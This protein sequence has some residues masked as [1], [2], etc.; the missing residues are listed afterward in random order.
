M[1]HF[2]TEREHNIMARYQLYENQDGIGGADI[3][4]GQY[5][6][7]QDIQAACDREDRCKRFSLYNRGGGVK[8]PWCMKYTGALGSRRDDHTFFKKM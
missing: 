8:T 6:R 5:S 4:C 7:V 1:P 3:S 2:I